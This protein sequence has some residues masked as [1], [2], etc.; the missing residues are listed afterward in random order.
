LR[1]RKLPFLKFSYLSFQ[2]HE[3]A[4]LRRDSEGTFRQTSADSRKLEHTIA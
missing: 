3:G 1:V 4:I 2:V